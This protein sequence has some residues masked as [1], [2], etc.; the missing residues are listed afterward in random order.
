MPGV[1]Y[2]LAYRCATALR[3]SLWKTPASEFGTTSLLAYFSVFTAGKTR[4]VELM[5]LVL[6]C[7]SPAGSRASTAQKSRCSRGRAREPKSSSHSPKRPLLPPHDNS[8]CRPDADPPSST[9][10]AQAVHVLDTDRR[11]VSDCGRR[12]RGHWRRCRGTIDDC[13]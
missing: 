10:A 3:R 13:L 9:M 11:C 6:V 5:A 2:W 1:R 8:C 12:F 7:R 4:A